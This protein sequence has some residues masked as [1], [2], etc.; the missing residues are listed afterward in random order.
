MDIKIVKKQMGEMVKTIWV[1]PYICNDFEAL[2]TIWHHKGSANLQN[3]LL[4]KVPLVFKYALC[5]HFFLQNL[6]LYDIIM[7]VQKIN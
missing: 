6:A 7:G 5:I 1:G 2:Y 4:E 3:K